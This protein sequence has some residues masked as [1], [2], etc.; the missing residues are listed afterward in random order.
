V[1]ID[2]YM[3]RYV[4]EGSVG[5]VNQN[6]GGFPVPRFRFFGSKSSVFSIFAEEIAACFFS[7]ALKVVSFRASPSSS[8]SES[9]ESE[10]ER[11][12]LRSGS[13]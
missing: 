9:D 8:S 10:P 5:V 12:S 6:K 1:K 7:S 11:L 3:P 4:F 2:R 13:G